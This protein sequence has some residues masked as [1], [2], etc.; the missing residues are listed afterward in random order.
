MATALHIK[1]SVS[2]GGWWHQR[3]SSP[4]RISDKQLELFYHAELQASRPFMKYFFVD[5]KSVHWDLVFNLALMERIPGI[6]NRGL[7][8]TFIAT[9]GKCASISHVDKQDAI[10]IASKE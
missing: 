2:S 3:N 4:T 7:G 5:M 1:T 9:T 6:L 10:A 8:M